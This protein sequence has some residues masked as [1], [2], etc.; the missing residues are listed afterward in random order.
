MALA[1]EVVGIAAPRL[2]AQIVR[3]PPVTDKG[4]PRRFDHF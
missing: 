4:V 2:S 3:S 1:P